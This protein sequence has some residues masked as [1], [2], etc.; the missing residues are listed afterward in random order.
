MY[1]MCATFD[2]FYPSFS[3]SEVYQTPF[4]HRLR[5]RGYK[6]SCFRYAGTTVYLC[7]L[8]G[9]A[10]VYGN[11]IVPSNHRSKKS[12]TPEKLVFCCNFLHFLRNCEKTTSSKNNK[13]NKKNQKE[14]LFLQDSVT[15]VV[16]CNVQ[17]IDFV[18]T[19]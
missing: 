18:S 2:C 19:S 16:L 7:Y 12:R 8:F 17:S 6:E 9:L 11:K 1:A 5:T 14:H 10:F 4:L 3:R 15:S 13:K